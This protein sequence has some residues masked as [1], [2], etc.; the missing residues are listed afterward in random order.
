VLPALQKHLSIQSDKADEKVARV[1]STSES[2]HDATRG[3]FGQHH[4][5]LEPRHVHLLA[6]GKLD[7]GVYS[8]HALMWQQTNTKGAQLA[9]LVSSDA[10]SSIRLT[11]IGRLFSLYRNRKRFDCRRTG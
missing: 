7:L 3:R 8:E 4:R 1:T 5:K 2:V 11:P 6:I 10:P 9:L